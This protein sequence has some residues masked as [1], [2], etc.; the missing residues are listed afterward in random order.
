MERREEVCFAAAAA[1][2]D[3]AE[4]EGVSLHDALI[5]SVRWKPSL[6]ELRVTL[7]AGTLE[8]SYET[9]D[10]IYR[11]ARLG[12]H[13]IESLRN[14]ACNREACVLYQEIDIDDDDG[15]LIHRLLFWSPRQ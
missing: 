14:A 10:L 5:D 11:G 15:T 4:R 2:L 1:P 13:R 9:I 3:V 8:V 7:V 12:K 6:A